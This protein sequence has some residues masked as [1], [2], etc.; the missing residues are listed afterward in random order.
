[1]AHVI[2]I[3][4][5]GFEE[6]EAVTFIDILRRA[7][8][9]VSVLG[10]KSLEVRGSHDLRIRTDGLLNDFRESYDGIVLP[11]GQPGTKNLSDS[12]LVLQKVKDA[13]SRGLLC[14]A[15]CA[16]PSVFAE[17]GILKGVKATCYPGVNE[18]L[19]DAIFLEKPVVRDKNVITS[20]GVG[21]AIDFSLE[22]ISYLTNEEAV[23]KIK[24]SIIYMQ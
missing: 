9:Q 6:T 15:I 8:I 10:L 18:R 3:L 1:M 23:E 2:T 12:P 20:R 7:Q 17:A 4:A 16:A 5:D 19:T 11:G 24:K 14:A 13:F 22:L 21:T